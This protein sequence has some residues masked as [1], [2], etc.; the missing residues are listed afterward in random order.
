MKSKSNIILKF[1]ISVCLSILITIIIW[2]LSPGLGIFPHLED[3]GASWYY[4]KL[5]NATIWGTITAWGG[6]LLHQISVFILIFNT[7]KRKKNTNN[8]FLLVN[9]FFVIAHVIQSHLFYDGL[10]QQVPVWSS[11]YSVIGMLSITLILLVPRRGMILGKFKTLPSGVYNFVRKYHSIYISWALI[12]TFWFHPAEGNIAILLGF[13]YMFLLMIQIS[14]ANTKIHTNIK[15]IT[16]LEI[17]VVIHGVSIVFMNSQE[18][19]PMFLTGFLFMFIFTYMN[20]LNWIKPVRIGIYLLYLGLCIY[21]YFFR[22]FDKIYEILFIPAT[23]YIV[24]ILL[25]FFLRF[26]INVVIIKK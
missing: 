5:P 22:G 19:W 4:W 15:W 9:L 18:I 26:L 25:I 24:A 10:A 7:K 11:Q 3:K 21:L 23:L 20:G 14:M 6:Y 2:W 13:F 8:I 16:I 12:Y 1:S 17:F